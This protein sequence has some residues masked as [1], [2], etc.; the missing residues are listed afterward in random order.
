MTAGVSPAAAAATDPTLTQARARAVVVAVGIALAVPY[1]LTGPGWFRE[2]FEPLRNAR[3]EG[4]WHAAGPTVTQNRPGAAIVYSLVFGPLGGHP[5]V[6]YGLLTALGVGVAL[7]LL[8]L[9]GRY[10]DP[11]L[12]LAV[13]LVYGLMPNRSSLTHWISTVHIWVA[14][15]ALIGALL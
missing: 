11:G 14:L 5:L 4:M 1:G 10:L 7:L 9:V 3:L 15:A 8:E 12:S 13:V 6:A 2:D